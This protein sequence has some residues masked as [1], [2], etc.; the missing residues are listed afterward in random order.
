MESRRSTSA[1]S[2]R[3]AASR[4]S[5]CSLSQPEI[6]R[7]PTCFT[8]P[9]VAN[10]PRKNGEKP[11]LWTVHPEPAPHALSYVRDHHAA[12]LRPSRSRSV[13]ALPS[14]RGNRLV[15]LEAVTPEAWTVPLYASGS[16]HGQLKKLGRKHPLSVKPEDVQKPVGW[17]VPVYAET[18]LKGYRRPTPSARHPMDVEP[19]EVDVPDGWTVPRFCPRAIQEG[20]AYGRK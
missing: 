3:S 11:H 4:G 7:G 13:A 20:T 18:S 19:H 14:W 12:F 9:T 8:V 1:G 16:T 17:T 6:L 10:A 5:A 2:I 15:Q